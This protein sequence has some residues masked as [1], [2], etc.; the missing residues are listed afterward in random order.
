MH[1]THVCIKQI[2]M[3]IQLYIE[4]NAMKPVSNPT[5]TLTFW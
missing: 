1:V 5:L 2:Y 4:S 3:Y